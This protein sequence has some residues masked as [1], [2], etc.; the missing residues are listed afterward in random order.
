MKIRVAIGLV[1]M[2][3][4]AVWFL[5]F[6]APQRVAAGVI[7]DQPGRYRSPDATSVVQVK[8]ERQEQLNFRL[9]A[10]WGH[11]SGSLRWCDPFPEA[12]GWYM[13]WDERSYLWMYVPEHGVGVSGVSYYYLPKNVASNPLTTPAEAAGMPAPFRKRLPT[14][15]SAV[16][17]SVPS[18]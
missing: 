9:T 8:R 1:I 3:S 5:L 10:K 15:V 16:L 6:H 13:C 18:P 14:N 17:C 7:I 2:V 11:G 12:S 4:L